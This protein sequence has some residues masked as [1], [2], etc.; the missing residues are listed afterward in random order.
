MNLLYRANPRNWQ[1]S[2]ELQGDFR[3]QSLSHSLAF[4]SRNL[5]RMLKF[6]GKHLLQFLAFLPSVIS[7]QPCHVTSLIALMHRV[8][9]IFR[10]CRLGHEAKAG[11]R[12]YPQLQN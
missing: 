12:S 3:S 8:L 11:G 2:F 6:L 4:M 1:A 9:D 10:T 7:V 5:L